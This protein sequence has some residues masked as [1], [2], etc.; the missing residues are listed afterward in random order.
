M[1]NYKIGLIGGDGTGPE[2]T[3][4]AVKVIKEQNPLPLS[5]GR[6][7]EE[8]LAQRRDRNAHSKQGAH[9]AL[10]PAIDRKRFAC[11]RSTGRGFRSAGSAH[12]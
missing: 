4:E 9:Q 3:V 7:Q 2:V 12:R 10:R 8:S 11:C 5:I 6:V 1:S